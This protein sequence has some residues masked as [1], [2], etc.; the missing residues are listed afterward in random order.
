MK[1]RIAR[2]VWFDIYGKDD[3]HEGDPTE[4]YRLEA[5]GRVWR[6]RVEGRTFLVVA[7]HNSLHD[8]QRFYDLR[9]PWSNVIEI[10]YWEGS[11][12]LKPVSNTIHQKK[13]AS[14]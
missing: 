4:I 12:K 5:I 11:E 6:E 13:H 10:Q 1:H 8:A 9:I 2:V 3:W 7:P 14:S